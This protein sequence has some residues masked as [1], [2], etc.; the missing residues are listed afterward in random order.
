MIVAVD[1]ASLRDDDLF[2]QICA[3]TGPLLV[4]NGV[5]ILI[6]GLI[7]YKSGYNPTDH[8]PPSFDL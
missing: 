2:V 1:D 4:V 7:I 5:I 6:N 8:N 3:K